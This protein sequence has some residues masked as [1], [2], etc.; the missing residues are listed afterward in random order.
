MA[1]TGRA[2]DDPSTDAGGAQVQVTDLREGI[3]EVGLALRRPESL[4]VRWRDRTPQPTV[5]P[6]VFPILLL[7]AILGLAAYGLT[8]GLDR[9]VHGMLLG[10]LKAPL[11]AGTAWTLALPALYILNSALGSKLDSSTTLLAALATVSFGAL[12]MLASVPINWFFTLAT[13]WPAMRWAVNL[14]IFTGVG[15][16]MMDVFLR[17][18]KALEPDRR[19]TFAVLW[20]GLVCVIGTELMALV[21]LFDF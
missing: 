10:A 19:R 18:M 15:V 8:L 7:N 2:L 11:A 5:K 16:C 6:I 20:L 14:T 1:G 3:R 12:A 4:A 21:H 17:V 9:G 13:P